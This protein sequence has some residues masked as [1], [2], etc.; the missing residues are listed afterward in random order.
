MTVKTAINGIYHFSEG[1]YYIPDE[2]EGVKV[3]GVWYKDSLPNAPMFLGKHV[4]GTITNESYPHIAEL[5]DGR[6][7]VRIKEQFEVYLQRK[8]L[9][10]TYNTFDSAALDFVRRLKDHNYLAYKS[11]LKILIIKIFSLLIG[12][13][14]VI[15]AT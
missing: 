11:H 2:F 8:G 15:F 10:T 1:P 4:R 14:V 6:Y 3:K 5:E 13:T 9:A 12:I 7:L